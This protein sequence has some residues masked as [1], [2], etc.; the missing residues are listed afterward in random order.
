MPPRHHATERL[1]DR[2]FLSGKLC[3]ACCMHQ[4]SVHSIR[5]ASPFVLPKLSRALSNQHPANA[6]ECMPCP[7][8]YSCKNGILGDLKQSKALGPGIIAAIVIASIVTGTSVD[9]RACHLKHCF[10]LTTISV[11]TAVCCYR[12]YAQSGSITC[13]QISCTCPQILS[14]KVYKYMGQSEE[15][16]KSLLSDD[17][18][19]HPL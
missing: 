5:F 13:P 15:G 11:A 3:T 1:P 14:P 17:G 9:K 6:T 4:E 12:R 18:N 16:R 10:H 8:D 2:K 19:S 7:R